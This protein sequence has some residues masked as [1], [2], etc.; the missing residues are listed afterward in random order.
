[1]RELNCPA[2]L[3]VAGMVGADGHNH[4]KIGG[5]IQRHNGIILSLW[6]GY[7]M[8][9][10][11]PLDLKP[12]R[13]VCNCEFTPYGNGDEDYGEE[14]WHYLRKCMFCGNEWYGLHCLH[15]GWQNPCPECGVRPAVVAESDIELT[16]EL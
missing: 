1:M 10:Q 4:H 14:S 3:F 12:D 13:D 5:I 8:N 2:I 16:G 6:G 7:S 15:D 11:S 9:E